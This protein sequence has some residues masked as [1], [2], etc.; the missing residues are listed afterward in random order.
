MGDRRP[1]MTKFGFH[2]LGVSNYPAW[3]KQMKGYLASK[4][5][6]LALT[7][8]ADPN[9]VQAKGLMMMCVQEC[10]LTLVENAANAHD[11]WQA[12]AN[13]YQQQSS[14]NV[15]RLK[16]EFSNLEKKRDE[17]ITEFMSRVSDLREQIQAAT[18]NP[19]PETDVIV[20]VLNAL[21][22]RF[23]MI[24]TVIEAMPALPTLAEVTSKLLMVEA[25]KSRGTES[26]H[27]TN[28]S[29]LTSRP[30]G[31][32][33][34]RVY[35]PPHRRVN[36]FGGNNNY[37]SNNQ[38]NSG[39]RIFGNRSSSSSTRE[40]RTCYYCN[41]PGHLKKE[42]RKLKADNAR[43]SSGSNGNNTTTP[44][45][46]ALS[47][48]TAEED[49]SEDC[50]PE[51][52]SHVKPIFDKDDPINMWY[53]DSGATR[54]ITK[55]KEILHNF[56]PLERERTVTYGN[57]EQVTVSTHGDVILGRSVSP[58]IRLMMKDVLYS[59]HNAFNLLSVSAAAANGVEFNFTE[60]R[61]MA[62]K[63]GEL[64]LG[65]FKESNGLYKL[66]SPPIYP[67]QP[68]DGYTLAASEK[69]DRDPDLWHRRLGHIGLSSLRKLI[70]NDM[71]KGL[72]LTPEDIDKASH[73]CDVCMKTKL[74]RQPFK[75]SE[76]KTDH[77]LDLI[78]TDLCGP[79]ADSLGKS[80]YIATFLDDYSGFSTV[81]L[82]KQKS[83][84]YDAV[85]N[86]IN[87]FETQTGR[88][89]KA[90]R[91]D[92]GGEYMSNALQDY[93]KEKGIQHQPTMAYSPQ[94]NGKAERLNRTL[95]E[96]AR[97][98]MSEA[99][100][101]ESLWGEAVNTANYLKNKSP[102]ANKDKTPWELFFGKK[103]DLSNLRPFG[104]EAFVHIPKT[105]RSKLDDTAEKGIMVGYMPNGYRILL[106]DNSVKESRDVVFKETATI[107]HRST[108]KEEQF[109][110]VPGRS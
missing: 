48:L 44:A 21:P 109:C 23:A 64:I 13:L 104:C 98:M 90:V 39:R 3:S 45:V 6:L 81:V 73:T 4:G 89:V 47:A 74:T 9:T 78:H 22:S 101:P 5:Y 30:F 16:R 14:A 72:P 56:R 35:V 42:C 32:G 20:A 11:A 61:C 12:L 70:L 29:N 86:T 52:P 10:H 34:P 62:Y 110:D 88:K 82:L 38:S 102:T 55:Y 71:V 46:V 28:G 77:P 26:A 99:N 85:V 59:P 100:L 37:S 79:L 108:G 33:N 75:P 41:K 2:K 94:S 40:T 106:D 63:D 84:T 1:E 7:D 57:N 67:K 58:H 27:Y 17:N 87:M 93:F 51:Y 50:E 49:Y 8:P 105:K 96:K 25:D 15:L 95:Q 18:G 19:M 76:T 65:A 36:R 60:D 107:T 97:A 103:P 92:R 24:K 54:H 83:D 91:S 66:L 68:D 53:L 43:R 80:K 69:A 31:G